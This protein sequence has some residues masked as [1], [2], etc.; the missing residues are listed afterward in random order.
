MVDRRLLDPD[1]AHVG[2]RGSIGWLLSTESGQLLR[3]NAKNGAPR[4]AD[5]RLRAAARRTAS[6]AAVVRPARPGHAA[7]PAR[8]APTIGGPVVLV[9]YKTDAVSAGAR[10][11]FGWSHTD[12]SWRR[13]RVPS[14][15]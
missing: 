9:D 1:Q 7:R 11:R 5:L 6:P 10:R 8:R 2:G 15:R 3:S 12:R 4:I 14:R 13:T